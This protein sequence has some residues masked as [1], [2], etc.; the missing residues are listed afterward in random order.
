MSK[1]FETYYYPGIGYY[2]TE[3]ELTG[4]SMK[5]TV[6]TNEVSHVTRVTGRYSE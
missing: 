1:T 4:R 6:I 2:R 3:V 5:R